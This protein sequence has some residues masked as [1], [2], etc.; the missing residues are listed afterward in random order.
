MKTRCRS[1]ESRRM[2]LCACV[3]SSPPPAPAPPRRRLRRRPI[4]SSKRSRSVTCGIRPSNRRLRPRLSVITASTTRLDDV[5]AAG[6]QARVVFDETLSIGARAH[7]PRASLSRANQVDA[8]AAAARSRVRPLADPARWKSGAGIRWSTRASP[9]TR[10][11]TCWRATLRRCPRDCSNVGARLDELPRFLAQV[12]EVLE[13]ARVPK[14][15]AETAVRQNAGLISMLD[16]EIARQ[17]PR[18]SGRTSRRSCAPA[19]TQRAQRA[20][21]APDLAREAPGSRSEGRFPARRRALR[22]QARVRTVLAAVAPGDPRA[23][24]SRTHGHARRDVRR[25]RAT[26]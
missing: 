4:S 1:R 21:P 9:A 22:P 15:H 13:P 16:G 20:D 25:S 3:P 2:L 18:L 24:R 14:V 10:C 19:S 26:C 12:R 7:R 6:W 23:G 5:S 11:T 8:A 17:S